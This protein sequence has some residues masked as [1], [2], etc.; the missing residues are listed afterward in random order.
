M[1]PGNWATDLAGGSK[2]GYTLIWVLLMSNL[3]ALLLAKSECEARYSKRQRPGSGQPGDLSE[4][5]EFHFMGIGRNCYS[6]H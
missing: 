6:C 5:D 1:D 3:M 2:Y 4:K